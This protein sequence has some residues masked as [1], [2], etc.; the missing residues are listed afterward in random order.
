LAQPPTTTSNMAPVG[1]AR[2]AEHGQQRSAK[3]GGEGCQDGPTSRH[4]LR[5]GAGWAVQSV[6]RHKIGPRLN[7]V[8]ARPGLGRFACLR[9][10]TG[11]FRW[12]EGSGGRRRPAGCGR[13]FAP[14]P[15]RAASQ[16]P[17]RRA[18]AW[19]VWRCAHLKLKAGRCGEVEARQDVVDVVVIRADRNVSLH[20]RSAPT[21]MKTGQPDMS[22]L[23]RTDARGVACIELTCT[24]TSSLIPPSRRLPAC[25][26]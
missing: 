12:A 17:S 18:G 23:R 26:S 2:R 3:R 25:S 13:R 6:R 19:R 20:A 4:T 10:P 14:S 8:R 21:A 22:K 9:P 15:A 16:P 7:V 5:R 11:S 1:P 24:A